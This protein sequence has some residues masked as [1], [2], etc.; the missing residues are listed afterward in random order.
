VAV[1]VRDDAQV[2]ARVAL[3]AD[4]RFAL[5]YRH[6]VYEVPA[7][8]RFVAE[9]DGRFRL[10]GVSSQS[11]AVLD[12]YAAEGTRVRDEQGWHLELAD[13]PRFD[14]LGLIA[15]E[16]GQRTL[17]VGDRRVPLPTIGEHLTISVTR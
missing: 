17:V 2:V 13:P 14:E 8:E 3:P 11:E 1:V 9:P 7:F 10:V 12:Y 5:A 16:V 15:T 6:S 4:G